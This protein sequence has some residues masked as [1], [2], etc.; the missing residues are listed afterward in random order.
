MAK[1]MVK[2]FGIPS[3]QSLKIKRW[4]NMCHKHYS[5]ESRGGY[6]IIGKGDSKVKKL[7]K[8]EC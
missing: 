2:K 8:R 6:I 7:T 4:K 1:A 3:I 5:K